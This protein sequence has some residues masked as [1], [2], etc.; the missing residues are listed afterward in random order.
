MIHKHASLGE[1]STY[2]FQ[3]KAAQSGKRVAG[4]EWE[5]IELHSER[6]F[7]SYYLVLWHKAHRIALKM[8]VRSAD[9]HPRAVLTRLTWLSSARWCDKLIF[10]VIPLNCATPHALPGVILTNVSW[11][12]SLSRVKVKTLM[13]SISLGSLWVLP[14]SIYFCW[15][16]EWGKYST[17]TYG[18]AVT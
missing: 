2:C 5:L 12:F 8:R 3:Q 9:T 10:Y 17:K 6:A 11:S 4:S 13:P 1:P 7:F 18:V 15:K 14:Y 16:Y